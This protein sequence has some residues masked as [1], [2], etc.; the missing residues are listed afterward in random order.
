MRDDFAIFILSHGRADNVHTV[1]T[2][3]KVNYS[4]KWYIL[5]D[6][7]D[8]QLFKYIEN[9]GKEHVII[10]NKDEALKTFDIMD[11]FEGK[12]VPTFARNALLYITKELG[13]TYFLELEDDYVDF[14]IRIEKDGHLPIWPIVDFDTIIDAYLEFL[15]SSGAYTIAFAQT[16]EMAGGVNGQIYKTK[17][18]RKAMNA[19][20]CRVD[21]PFHFIGR[22]NDDVNAYISY[23]KVGGL[24]LSTAI[25]NLCQM[26]TQ[27]SSGGITEAYKA[28]GTY[29][30]SFYSVML[31][32]DC[33]KISCMGQSHKRIHH[34]IDNKFAYPM[35]ISDRFKK[36]A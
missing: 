12:G 14:S 29:V 13:F 24:F 25:V 28:F 8:D 17:L 33:V 15:D 7:E 11:N 10:F 34:E 20:F 16:G 9:F 21:N 22:F 27:S 5:C 4:G 2:L 35:I 19:F 1:N 31:R 26:V 18:K 23:G 3:Q 36:N 30:K 32:P 6:D